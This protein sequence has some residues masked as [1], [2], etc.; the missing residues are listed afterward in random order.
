MLLVS[1]CST[2]KFMLSVAMMV[3]PSLTRYASRSVLLCSA[4]ITASEIVWFG[5][6]LAVQISVASKTKVLKTETKA[7]ISRP[8]SARLLDQE[9][10]LSVCGSAQGIG[11]NVCKFA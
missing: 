8:Q 9:Q 6:L 7:V 10:V 3:S 11:N 5:F 1:S 4:L 2:V